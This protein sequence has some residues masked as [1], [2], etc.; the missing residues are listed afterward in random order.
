MLREQRDDMIAR[1]GAGSLREAEIGIQ[2][3]TG[4]TLEVELDLWRQKVLVERLKTKK[5]RP[6]INV[7]RR[8]VERFYNDHHAE[9]NPAPSVTVRVILVESPATADTVDQTLKAGTP[10]DQVAT[11]HSLYRADQGGLMEPFQLR[12]PFDQF[13]ELRWPELNAAVRSLKSG[14]HSQRQ[15]IQLGS[16]PGFGW[17]MLQDLQTGEGEALRDVFLDIE[18]RLKNEQYY[19]LSQAYYNDLLTEGN[20]TPIESMM[21][22][23]LDIA[24]TRF[25]RES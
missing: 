4:H 5:L 13:A 20:F 10:F 14:D 17:V 3:Q 2:Q 25:A 23:L 1:Y 21:Q 15:S 6:K 22:R 7:T 24:M 11:Q 19:K 18:N 12:G 16:A 9:F 8:D